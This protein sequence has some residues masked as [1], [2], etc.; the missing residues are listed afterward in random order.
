VYQRLVETIG[1]PRGQQGILRFSIG[2][3][4]TTTTRPRSSGFPHLE[5]PR[6]TRTPPVVVVM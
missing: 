4:S 6:R 2:V 1:Q 5:A 3:Y